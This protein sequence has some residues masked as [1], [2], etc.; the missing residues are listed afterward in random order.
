MKDK[1]IEKKQGV[2]LIVLDGWG[3][4]E[5]WGGNAIGLANT[6]VM[7]KLREGFPNIILRASGE[8]VGLPFQEPGNSEVGHLNIGSGQI[9]RQ[10]LPAINKMIADNSFYDNQTL[11]EA[12]DK[13]KSRSS[14]LHLVGLISDGGIHSHINHL[15]ALLTLAKQKD[16]NNVYIHTFTDGR[17]CSPTSG[18]KFIREVQKKIEEIGVGSIATVSG[19]YF[20]MD[21][22]GHW[23]RVKKV[24]DLLIQGVGEETRTAEAS[25]NNAYANGITDEFIP[26]KIIDKKGLIKDNDSVIFFNFRSDRA[27]QLVRALTKKDFNEFGRKKRPQNLFVVTFASYQEGLDVEVAFKPQKVINPLAQVLANRDMTHCHIAETEKYPHVTYFFNGGIEEPFAGEKRILVP[28]PKVATFDLKP[29]MSASEITEQAIKEVG[30][31]DFMVI[32]YANADMVGHTGKMEPAIKAVE[33]VDTCLGK[34]LKRIETVNSL[35]IITADHGNAEQMINP[36]TGMEDTE[37][38]NNPVPFIITDKKYKINGSEGRLCDIAPTVLDIYDME[39]P[40]Q[41]MGKS[42]ITS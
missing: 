21:R 22:D 1:E 20:A 2:V 15:F 3:L 17:D 42:L 19:R 5:R 29:E 33:E 13:A 32:N 7:D 34:L 4:A 30:K 16:F 23:D 27:R 28:S 11:K 8:A 25:I 38:T 39:K 18:I 6:P 10:G 40:D 35:A 9:A 24:Y 14:A 36:L 31:H 12:I 37:H 26:P 41:M